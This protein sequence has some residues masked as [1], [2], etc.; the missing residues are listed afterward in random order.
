MQNAE[1]TPNR[2]GAVFG[3]AAEPSIRSHAGFDMD[4]AGEESAESTVIYIAQMTAELVKLA[5]FR[6]L[7]LLAYLLE[8]ARLEAEICVRVG[9]NGRAVRKGA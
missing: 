9:P 1:A 7:D 3:D 6:R 5:R 4:D 2:G 8:I